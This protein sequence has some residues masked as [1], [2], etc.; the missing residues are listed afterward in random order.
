[1]S[2]Q[3]SQIENLLHHIYQ[4]LGCNPDD[5][6]QIKPIDGGWENALSYE[7]TRKDHKKARVWRKDLDDNKIENIKICL[8]QFS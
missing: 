6:I 1:M 4:E 3:D 8:R 7:V 5:L 2:V